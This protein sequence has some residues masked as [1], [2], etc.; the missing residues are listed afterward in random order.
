MFWKK[1][2]KQPRVKQT[3]VKPLIPRDTLKAKITKEIEALTAGQAV[4]YQIPEYFTFARFLGIELNPTFPQKGKK[5]RMIIYKEIADGKPAG[6][7]QITD[8]TNSASYC[9]DWVSEKDTERCGHV[10]RFQ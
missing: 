7:K 1:Q 9:A 10:M 4:I 6:D 5:Y 8:Y 2:D 3:K